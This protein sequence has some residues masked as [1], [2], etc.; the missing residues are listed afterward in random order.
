MR[1]A[2]RVKAACAASGCPRLTLPSAMCQ[3]SCEGP[4]EHGD[5]RSHSY[6]QW[7][8]AGRLV[9]PKQLKGRP[10]DVTHPALAAQKS[11]APGQ[12]LL[13]ALRTHDTVGCLC[14]ACLGG[15]ALA[16]D[17]LLRPR[18]CRMVPPSIV[19]PCIQAPGVLCCLSSK[20]TAASTFAELT[21][22]CWAACGSYR[23]HTG[24]PNVLCMEASACEMQQD[25]A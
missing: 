17:V 19:D 23:L 22:G 21:W 13:A 6:A 25:H 11:G 16:G 7:S 8:G 9:T 3:L 14:A 24:T 15:C 2:Q 1:R 12:S 18:S 4:A 10:R 5:L 20:A